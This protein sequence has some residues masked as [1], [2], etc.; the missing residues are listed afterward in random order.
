MPDCTGELQ[1]GR[2]RGYWTSAIC[3]RTS[4][5]V[6]RL[7]EMKN[8]IALKG[9]RGIECQWSEGLNVEWRKFS[10]RVVMGMRYA[11]QCAGRYGRLYNISIC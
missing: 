5:E 10:W 3:S 2:R 1:G 6:A 7:R 4:S 8:G 11:I 9:G